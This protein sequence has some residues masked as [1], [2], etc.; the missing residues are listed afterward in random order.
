[1]VKI[2]GRWQ[3]AAEY[4]DRC[5]GG[6]RIREVRL[7]GRTLYYVF[8]DGHEL[9]LLCFCCGKPLVCG[10]LE[11]SHRKMRGR[12]LEAMTVRPIEHEDGERIPC[13]ELEFSGK[14]L[15][16][17]K[18]YEPLSPQVAAGLRHPKECQ[19]RKR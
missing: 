7:Q 10:N 6:Q 8:E 12:R 18:V 5:I 11:K 2:D 1:M 16:P 3:C 17:G 15:K 4:L 9:P 19:H 14:G 13:F